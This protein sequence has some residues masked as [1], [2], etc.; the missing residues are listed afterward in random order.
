MSEIIDKL[1]MLGAAARY[2]LCGNCGEG[3]RYILGY[4]R[5]IH[6][7]V[8]PDGK[9]MNLLK[10]LLT[11][12]CENNCLYCE[13]RRGRDVKRVMMKPEEIAYVFDILY[14]KGMVKGLFLSS[15]I[16][17]N[18]EYTMQQM[19]DTVKILR[20]KYEFNGYVH[21]KILP[22]TSLQ[23]LK[24]AIKVATRV[25]VNLEAPS[26]DRLKR[27]A[28]MKK[29]KEDLL[30][31][32]DTLSKILQDFPYKDQTTQFIVGAAEEKDKEIIR[33]VWDLYTKRK[34]SRV[35]YS[36]FQPIKG[37]PLE[38]KKPERLLREHR[39]YQV[40]YLFRRYGFKLEDIILDKD[41]NLSFHKD[42][43]LIWAERHIHLFP[44]EI[45]KAPY[46]LLLRIPGIGPRSAKGI[47]KL[48]KYGI[49]KELDTL[50]KTGCV[51]KR[52]IPFILINGKCYREKTAQKALF[53]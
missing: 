22:Q 13:N 2:D 30:K 11:N 7:V 33:V 16:R 41:G 47:I 1:K 5:Y 6:P 51:V 39:L 48:R 38:N 29:Y 20:S 4:N 3:T 40:D 17:K 45:N 52:A 12:D 9:R 10:I 32:I 19:I 28:P 24:E 21:L 37:T 42:P 15:G 18:S 44:M 23:T 43:K 8:L 14:R 46:E 26:E 36:A 49:I 53:G 27:I 34:V 35:Y 25:S 50:K 31:K